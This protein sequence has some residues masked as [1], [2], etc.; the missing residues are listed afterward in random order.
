[1]NSIYKMLFIFYAKVL[2][3]VY[4]ITKPALVVYLIML[5]LIMMINILEYFVN[6]TIHIFNS[7][8]IIRI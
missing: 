6:K 8:D 3:F 5:Y 4:F 7:K 2:T 1:M